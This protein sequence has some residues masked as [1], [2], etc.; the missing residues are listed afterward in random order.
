MTKIYGI[1]YSKAK[2]QINI[3]ELVNDFNILN[4]D[5]VK[6]FVYHTNKEKNNLIEKGVFKFNKKASNTNRKEYSIEQYT[7]S[8]E[9]YKN[10][11]KKAIYARIYFH[12]TYSGDGLIT[13][14]L[15]QN[16]TDKLDLFLKVIRKYVITEFAYSFVSEIPQFIEFFVR[17]I[18]IDGK[19]N[20]IESVA[21]NSLK[22]QNFVGRIQWFFPETALQ[23]SDEQE[24][25]IIEIIGNDRVKRVDNLLLIR[26]T[27]ND[28]LQLPE[29]LVGKEKELKDYLCDERLIEIDN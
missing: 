27:E 28:Y 14:T 16:Y 13:V 4:V 21:V 17:G 24:K 25:K 11:N 23:C 20:E 1:I 10:S 6:Y 15:F 18:H 2:T 9:F 22:K 7:V 19:E 12:K 29:T 5:N 3:N 8:L 26:C